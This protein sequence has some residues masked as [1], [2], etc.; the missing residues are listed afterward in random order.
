MR[1][2]YRSAQCRTE[3]IKAQGRYG[4]S[5]AIGKEV[6]GLDLVV[7]KKIVGADV[8]LVGPTL[9]N[10]VDYPADMLPNSALK[11]LVWPLYS[12]TRSIARKDFGPVKAGLQI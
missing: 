6:V 4:L 1:D 5:C 11:L 7:A 2:H 10:Y 8:P 3:L 12:C 9:G